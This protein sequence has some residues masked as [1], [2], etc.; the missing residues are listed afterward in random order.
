MSPHTLTIDLDLGL[1]S[2][3][4]ADP[5]TMTQ[6]LTSGSN[7]DAV[8]NNSTQVGML[9][10]VAPSELADESQEVG[11]DG[12]TLGIRLFA[13]LCC[14]CWFMMK[15]MRED[16]APAYAVSPCEVRVMG[17]RGEPVHIPNTVGVG[18]SMQTCT[19]MYFT[20]CVVLQ[21]PL[22]VRVCMFKFL[23]APGPASILMHTSLCD[24]LLVCA[25]AFA[26][27]LISGSHQEGSLQESCRQHITSSPSVSPP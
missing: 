8:L 6:T 9:G 25:C 3:H 15:W 22:S 5:A 19:R 18:A 21:R 24:R 27:C 10:V 12:H 13:L 20:R 17:L 16:A 26:M 4:T 1:V 14:G 11:M 2:D 23:P 7:S